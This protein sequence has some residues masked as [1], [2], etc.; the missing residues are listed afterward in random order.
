MLKNSDQ[1]E[2]KEMKKT[3]QKNSTTDLSFFYSRHISLQDQNKWNPLERKKKFISDERLQH[4]VYGSRQFSDTYHFSSVYQVICKVCL[5][6]KD[7]N[8]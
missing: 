4:T 5:E 1:R 3:N 8:I 6:S 2:K 7:L